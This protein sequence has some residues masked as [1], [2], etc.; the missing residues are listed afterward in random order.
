MYTKFNGLPEDGCLQSKHVA[1]ILKIKR[2]VAE[3]T[4]RGFKLILLAVGQSNG[5]WETECEI[6]A[7]RTP[8]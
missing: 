7:R 2:G 5:A 6:H 4:E 8:V 3:V 1:E